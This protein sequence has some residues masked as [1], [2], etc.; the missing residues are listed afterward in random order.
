MIFAPYE[1]YLDGLLGVKTSYGASV[2]IRN[3]A[4]SKKLD[5]FQKYVPELQESLRAAGR[6]PAFEAR[7]AIADGSGGRRV[8]RGR[9]AARLPGRRR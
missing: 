1:V 4:E 6:G 9:S 2:M 8:P 5:V 7:Q 3:D